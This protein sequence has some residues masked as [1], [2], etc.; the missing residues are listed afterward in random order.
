MAAMLLS[1][2]LNAQK[3]M[4]V[5]GVSDGKIPQS[6]I[7]TYTRK[8][9]TRLEKAGIAFQT[10]TDDK[11]NLQALDGITVALFPYNCPLNAIASDAMDK[12]V[13]RGGKIVACYSSDMALLRHLGIESVKFTSGDAMADVTA[14]AL[15][16]DL[17]PGLP[18]E[19]TQRSRCMKQA[20]LS[21]GAFVLG[22]WKK[23]NGETVS[24]IAATYNANGVYLSHV[25]QDQDAENGGRFWIAVLGKFIPEIWKNAAKTKM[26]NA[27]KHG[28]MTS[29][30]QIRERVRRT[31]NK[32]AN[33]RVSE[34]L[35]KYDAAQNAFRAEKHIDA[36]DAAAEAEKLFMDSLLMTY[37][38]R[39]GE[40]RGAWIH[41][42]YGISG[43]SWDDTIRTLAENGFNAIFPNMSWSYVADY[44]SEVLPVHPDVAKFG[45]Q[46]EACLAACKKYGVELHVWHVCW[47]MGHRTPDALVKQMQDAKRTQI[48]LDGTPSKFLA[49]HLEEN[50]QL[51]REAF[52]EIV[53]K[54]DVDGIHFDYIRYPDS[55][56]DFSPSARSA[57]E[58][59]LGMTV[60]NWPEDCRPGGKHYEA[61]NSWRQ[62]NISRLVEK[63]SEGAR[64]IRPGIKISAAVYGEW[65]GAK[66]WVAQDAERWVKNGWLDFIC[67][68]NYSADAEAFKG[69]LEKQLPITSPKLPIYPGIGAYL[70]ANPLDVAEQIDI[71]RTIGADG[72]VC[73][74]LNA[75]FADETLPALH[76]SSTASQAGA[77]LPH[78]SR[79]IDFAVT[80]GSKELDGALREGD[81]CLVT[82]TM[83]PGMNYSK[84]VKLTL[85]RNGC[86]YDGKVTVKIRPKGFACQFNADVHGLWRLVLTDGHR[87]LM[88]RSPVIQV[89]DEAEIAELKVRKG[90][91]Q[92]AMTGGLRVAVW[93]D[94][95]YGATV[96]LKELQEMDGID[97]APLHN[98]NP[99]NWKQIQ[100]LVLPQP[101]NNIP[102][103]R[104]KKTGELL[105]QF[106]NHGC[107]LLTTHAMV[108]TRG[109]VNPVPAVV[110][111]TV[112]T[113]VSADSWRVSG[114]HPIT[115]GLPLE[116]QK[117]TFGDMVAF[118]PA[119]GTVSILMAPDGSTVMAAGSFGR[120]RYVPCGLG[121]A[122]DKSDANAE[123][124]AIEKTLLKNAVLWLGK[125][126]R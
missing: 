24:G 99:E 34:A 63:V 104:D 107:G 72:F 89:L 9:K 87:R 16:K 60:A 122:I 50:W 31:E 82:V 83:P 39:G 44:N 26:G 45:D 62:D 98:L 35:A 27:V 19:F 17:L 93:Q 81:D 118:K 94:N 8:V 75:K 124:P 84:N 48:S 91:P 30:E 110:T 41:S 53:R 71:A 59:K 61:Y 111:E 52:L 109:F 106:V 86:D 66:E 78:H 47:N 70:T 96:L 29:A 14:M 20:V 101:R 58:K 76:L 108:G 15:E 3:L 88:A 22:K 103:F 120:G 105:A 36:F 95:S 100:V 6:E 123:L 10:I 11:L 28:G 73:F 69:W 40:L 112:A 97:A 38:S 80:P 68:M 4:L 116:P 114:K 33:V 32:Q 42:A 115:G 125:K 55:K 49:P 64:K 37:P 1:L 21:S 121:L 25:Y 2:S 79:H 126:I 67:P 102:L 92:F 119:K 12:F 65:D 85:E 74:A 54:Y 51:E 56:C 46:I 57:F 43:R 77:L 23:S 13:A 90:P 18:E 7:N 5:T 113:P 117:T